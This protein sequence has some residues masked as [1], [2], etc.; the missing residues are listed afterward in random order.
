[1]R[2]M[3]FSRW[4][5]RQRGDPQFLKP[6]PLTVTRKLGGTGGAQFKK[7]QFLPTQ[8]YKVKT[9][10]QIF[11]GI[12]TRKFLVLVPLLSPLKWT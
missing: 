5:F 10:R 3:P 6:D 12:F 7:I 1:M 4:T 8:I 9:R 2:L 11:T